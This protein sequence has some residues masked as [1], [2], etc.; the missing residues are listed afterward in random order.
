MKYKKNYLFIAAIAAVMLIFNIRNDMLSD[1]VA[2]GNTVLAQE[3]PEQWNNIISGDV[4]NKSIKLTIDGKDTELSVSNKVYMDSNLNIMLPASIFRDAF[5]CS[6]NSYENKSVYIQKGALSVSIED[7]ADYINSG[8]VYYAMN[9]PMEIVDGVV[10]VQASIMEKVFGYTYKWDI[11]SNTV[12]LTDNK[13]GDNILPIRF[14]YRDI[15]KLPSIKN[16]GSLS[17]CWAFAALTALETSIMPSER[18]IFSV[19]NMSLDDNFN[20]NQNEG[21]DYTRAIAYLAAW[22]GPVTE[23]DD[24]YGDGV[25]NNSVPSAKHVQEVQIIDSKNFESIKKAVFLYGGVQSSLYTSMGN[26]SGVSKYYNKST[27]SYCYIGTQKPN[28]DVV[29]IGWDDNYS[30]SNFNANLDGDGAFICINSWGEDFGD[31]GLFYVSYYDSNIG[32]KNIV[33]TGIENNDNY[34]NIYQSDLCGWIGQ[35]GYESDTAYFANVYSPNSEETLKAVSFYATGKSTE[36]SIYLVEDFKDTNSFKS[37]TFLQG[38]TFANAG[39]YTVDLKTPVDLFEDKDYAIVIKITTPD[40]QRPVAVEYKGSNTAAN[41]DLSDGQGYISLSGNS[42]ERVEEKKNCN[43]CLKMF[44]D[45][46]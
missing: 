36:Y 32:M 8:S 9:N 31:N 43:L 25:A 35:L 19:D 11:N 29:I 12:Y 28:H 13:K 24:P 33:Y 39:Y 14:S 3:R 42:W 2:V 30:K 38:G 1:G 6:L 44:T 7:G 37:K 40:S 26:A 5:S 4:N 41:V 27:N 10:Y 18:F 17:T 16:Q 20:T 21:G 45:N 34:D 15:K 22:N 46:R 23:D